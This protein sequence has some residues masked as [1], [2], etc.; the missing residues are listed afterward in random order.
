MSHLFWPRFRKQSLK[1]PGQL[2]RLAKQYEKAFTKLKP[3]KRLEWLPALGSVSLEIVLKDR[4]L[5]LD[6]TPLQAAVLELFDTRR[7]STGRQ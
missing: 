4:T 3:E 2:G 5:E 6:V 7:E 1:L